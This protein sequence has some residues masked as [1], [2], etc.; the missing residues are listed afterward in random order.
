MDLSTALPEQ[1][2]FIRHPQDQ[3]ALLAAGPGTGKTWVLERRSEHLVEVG[4]D[5]SDIAVLTLTRSLAREL[6]DRIPHGFA[7]TLHSFALRHLNL[8]GDA[9]GR[10]VVSPWEQ[11]KIVRG[12][13]ALG[14]QIAFGAHCSMSSVDTFLRNLAASFREHQAIPENLSPVEAKLRQ[15]F[16]QHREVFQYRLLDELAYDLVMLIEAGTQIQNPPTHLL[17][18]EYQDLTAGELRLLQ[19]MQ[20]RFGVTVNAA[21]DDRQSIYGFREADPRALH[22]F[23]DVYGIE[24]PDYLSR[25]HRCPRLICDLANLVATPLPPLPGLARADLEPWPGQSDDGHISM[26][27]YP[28]PA[29]EARNVA[30]QCRKLIDGGTT[31]SEIIVVVAN[32]F[33][34]VCTGLMTAAAEQGTEGQFIAARGSEQDVPDEVILAIACARLL[35]NREDQM[36]W[37]TLVW[38]TP[39]LGDARRRNILEADGQTYLARLRYMAGR[40]NVVARP[41]AAGTRVCNNFGECE[42]V[43]LRD[44]VA[45]A[46]EE[47]GCSVSED[48]LRLLGDEPVRPT[49]AVRRL[50]EL[51]NVDS[52]EEPAE[53]SEAIA[54]HTIFSAKGL[55]ARHVFFVHAVNESFAGRGDVAS[56]LRQAYVGVTR[57]SFALYISGARSLRGTPLEHQVGVTITRPADFLVGHCR[58]LGVA[59]QEVPAGS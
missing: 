12:D 14:Y 46:A 53:G 48:G 9:W 50:I 52:N 17:V 39:G 43:N 42:T 49:E 58:Q 19:L 37:R 22:R 24:G 21:G 7:S 8:L 15:V 38:A 20:D 4:V 25:S 51:D 41:L 16:I 2:S 10:T 31:P 5:S 30:R 47:L 13:L 34:T 56:G 28:S 57:A 33:D 54:V 35:S 27:S 45:A 36:A 18:D 29:S 3:P 26:T 32:N 6:S 55:E 1:L 23:P 40:N 11:R 59:V 44:L